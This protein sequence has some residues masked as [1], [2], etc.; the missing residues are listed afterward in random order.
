MSTLERLDVLV[1]A[2]ALALVQGCFVPVPDGPL[3]TCATPGDAGG[4][5]GTDVGIC[6]VRDGI[7]GTEDTCH[8]RIDNNGNGMVDCR[9][10]ACL[11][12]GFCT[13]IIPL[14]PRISPEGRPPGTTC[15]A[16]TTMDDCA[17]DAVNRCM[18]S[19]PASGT[20]GVCSQVPDPASTLLTCN[21]RIDNDDDGHFDCGDSGCQGVFETCCVIE[22]TNDVCRDLVDNDRS[23]FADC[24][25]N[26]CRHP[27]FDFVSAC[28]TETWAGQ[29][30]N[31]RNHIDD[32]RDHYIDCAD[33]ECL[34]DPLCTENCTN[35]V[36]DNLDGRTDCL[37]PNCFGVGACP[38]IVE[39]TLE[40]C[41]D[42]RDNDG[43]EYV[44]CADRGCAMIPQCNTEHS[45]PACSDGIDNDGNG[46]I[47]CGDFSCT[48]SSSGASPEA[49]AYCQTWILTH[50]EGTF[51][52]CTDGIDNDHNGYA[53]CGDLGC[54]PPNVVEV[55]PGSDPLHPTS[56]SP[57][58]ESIGTDA[59]AN[60]TDGRDNDA[61]GFVDCEDW[62]CNYNPATMAMCAARR[63]AMTPRLPLVCGSY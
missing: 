55:D 11:Q 2:C 23:G 35:G 61:D 51:A 3:G 50:G 57:C 63:A 6:H 34:G 58:Q 40:L 43:N 12:H 27:Q 14:T 56:R 8:D 47:D 39:N 4:G 29:P 15:A 38:V 48:R 42:H 45:G 59:M 18:W 32:D 9:D 44:D 54:H 16:H 62:D 7:E 60:C 1:L 52:R 5:V 24:E 41:T 21:D 28:K 37:D 17:F 22:A 36:D 10:P 20:T 49:V 19:V 46:Y 13:Q 33:K 53:D 25:E 26:A 31:C 30:G